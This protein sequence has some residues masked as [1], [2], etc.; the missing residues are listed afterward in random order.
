MEKKGKKKNDLKTKKDFNIKKKK[1]VKYKEVDTK[2]FKKGEFITSIVIGIIFLVLLG[3]AV[4][5]SVFVPVTLVAL[6]LLLFSICYYYID[7]EKSKKIV[8]ILFSVGV[9]IIIAEVVYTLVNIL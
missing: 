5:D 8:Y 6:A 1:E 3:F 2:K 7:N 9:L 4:T